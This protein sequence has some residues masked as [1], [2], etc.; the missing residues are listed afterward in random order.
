MPTDQQ[1]LIALFQRAL[2]EDVGISV[3]CSNRSVLANELYA[4]RQ[5]SRDMTLNGIIIFKSPNPNELWLVKESLE[6][7]IDDEGNATGG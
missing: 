6:L 7:E 1:I 2:A 5:D 4:A 3:P